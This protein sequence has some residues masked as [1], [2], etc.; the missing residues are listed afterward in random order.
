MNLVNSNQR[1]DNTTRIFR[2]AGFGVAALLGIGHGMQYQVP[3]VNASVKLPEVKAAIKPS[4]VHNSGFDIHLASATLE[5]STA[6]E[7]SAQIVHKGNV[8]DRKNFKVIDDVPT[9]VTF[10]GT[11]RGGVLPAFERPLRFAWASFPGDFTLTLV[12]NDAGGSQTYTV[13]F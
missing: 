12:R 5:V 6:G 11:P 13:K 7:Y 1:S 2:L 4:F 10:K 8:V 3:G 9:V